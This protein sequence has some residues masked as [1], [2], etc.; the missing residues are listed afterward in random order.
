M[1]GG[2][3]SNLSSP[4]IRFIFGRTWYKE[5]IEICWREWERKRV[6]IVHLK[7]GSNWFPIF[8]LQLI[9]EI[10]N[11]NYYIPANQERKPNA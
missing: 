10:L 7:E 8:A 4:E 3:N 11:S 2:F 1:F 5:L 6:H 9:T